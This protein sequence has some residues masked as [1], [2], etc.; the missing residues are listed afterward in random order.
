MNKTKSLKEKPQPETLKTDAVELMHVELD[1]NT[2]TSGLE[3]RAKF[4]TIIISGILKKAE[5]VPVGQLEDTGEKKTIV[6]DYD[7]A[8]DIAIVKS[9]APP[10]VYRGMLAMAFMMITQ[11]QTLQRVQAMSAAGRIVR[12]S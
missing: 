3:L 11:N 1:F 6:I 8:T 10:L 4:P 5:F 9:N 12:P 2:L 7:S